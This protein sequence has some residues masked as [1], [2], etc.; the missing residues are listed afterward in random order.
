ML[1]QIVPQIVTPYGIAAVVLLLTLMPS[2]TWNIVALLVGLM[3]LNLAAMIYAREILKVAAFPLQ[4]FGTVLGVLQVALSV[5]MV[6]YG[7]RL[8]LAERFGIT[9]PGG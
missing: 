3:I 6:V 2:K 5:Q 7:I 8:L 1:H 4:I 9:F